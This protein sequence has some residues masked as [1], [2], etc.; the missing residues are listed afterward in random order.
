[1]NSPPVSG[2]RIFWNVTITASVIIAVTATIFSLTRNVN[3]VFPF[4]YFLPIILFVNF[5]RREE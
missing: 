1:M 2:Q 4:L 5:Y 3:D